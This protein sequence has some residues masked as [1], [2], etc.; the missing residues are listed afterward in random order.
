MEFLCQC[1]LIKV[2]LCLDCLAYVVMGACAD[3][4]GQ[5][6]KKMTVWFSLLGTCRFTAHTDGALFPDFCNFQSFFESYRD[7]IMRMS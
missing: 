5:Y 7:P 2:T 6:G 4:I 1:C 3:G